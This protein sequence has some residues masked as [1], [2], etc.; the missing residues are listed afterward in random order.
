M[1]AAEEGVEAGLAL[2]EDL[3]GAGPRELDEGE[4]D[5]GVAPRA[6]GGMGGA[7]ELGAELGDDVGAEVRGEGIV[8]GYYH[9]SLAA[10]AFQGV[11]ADIRPAK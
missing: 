11:D 6:E 2:A 3:G 1:G 5:G 8:D 4:R 7:D 9:H 10:E